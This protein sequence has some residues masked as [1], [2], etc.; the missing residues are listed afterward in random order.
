MTLDRYLSGEFLYGDDFSPGQINQWFDDEKDAYVDLTGA[1]VEAYG[2]MQWAVRYGYSRLPA[3]KQ[4][5][6]V[7]GFGSGIGGELVPVG[8]R[9]DKI[10]IVESSASYDHLAPGLPAMTSFVP[11][12]PSGD[13][14]FDD[15]EADLI[16]CFG[17]LHHIPNVSHVLRE[18]GRVCEADGYLLL[19][20]PITSMGDWTGA[21]P[22]LTPHER[23]IPLPI[24]RQRIRDAGF[25]ITSEVLV[26]FPATWL[27]W[28]RG[29]FEPFNTAW[30]TV[31]DRCLASFLRWNLRYHAT[32]TLR[33][34]RPTS[35]AIVARRL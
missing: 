9:A 14:A 13:L 35:A 24:L 20:E 1:G 15:A 16:T 22:G 28:Q 6:H 33:K 25:F 2:Y 27:P 32:S 18:L 4:F 10:S 26:G 19:R 17:V 30:S 5:R 23:G 34:L 21:R 3:D 8:D 12:D 29:W 11:A 7:V 31:A